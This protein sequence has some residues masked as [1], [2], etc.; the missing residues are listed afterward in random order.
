[1]DFFPANWL[2][3]VSF[4]RIF[5]FPVEMIRT[6][7]AIII[8]VL[9]IK[10]IYTFQL[11]SEKRIAYLE[12][13]HTINKERKKLARE[14]HDIILQQLFA[15]GMDIE[16][17]SERACNSDGYEDRILNVKQRLNETMAIIRGFIEKTRSGTNEVDDL[18]IRL[19]QM[20]IQL[21][22]KKNQKLTIHVLS[23]K[24]TYGFLSNLNLNHL[25]YVIQESVINAIKHSNANVIDIHMSANMY[26]LLIEVID[27][28]KG[29]DV[30]QSGFLKGYGIKS[31]LERVSIMKGEFKIQ[32]DGKG[33][34]VTIIAPWED[35]AHE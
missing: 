32:S 20:L 7:I 9:F 23:H 15:T 27:D 30:S 19:K 25:F 28:G 3:E 31:M 22:C 5:R 34:K 17:L 35:V 4:L 33:T 16:E 1:M 6:L 10:V 8:T 24:I 18:T 29:F 12:K 14:L 11:E 2:N 13:N 21:K 26:N